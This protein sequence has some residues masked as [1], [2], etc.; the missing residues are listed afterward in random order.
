MRPTTETEADL[1][2]RILFCELELSD[3]IFTA[4]KELQDYLTERGYK[5]K[6]KHKV[7][8]TNTIDLVA[9]N[10][11][12]RLAILIGRHAVRKK[13]VAQ[14]KEV[15]NY[16]KVILLRGDARVENALIEGINI[17]NVMSKGSL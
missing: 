9:A 14:L 15:S 6:M 7:S 8:E 4:R 5:S 16:K 10:G 11:K 17:I 13:R 2:L 1:D 12:E 3:D